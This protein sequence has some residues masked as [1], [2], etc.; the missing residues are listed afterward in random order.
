MID[1]TTRCVN[2]S[3]KPGL[4]REFCPDVSGRSMNI[5]RIEGFGLQKNIPACGGGRYVFQAAGLRCDCAG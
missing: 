3:G 2:G 1:V 4:L 5:D